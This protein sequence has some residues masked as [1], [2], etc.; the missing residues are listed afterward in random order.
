MIVLGF[1]TDSAEPYEG[2]TL[3]TGFILSQL[4]GKPIEPLT[5]YQSI[6]IE[7]GEHKL[8]GE[9]YW[10]LRGTLDFEDDFTEPGSLTLTTLP[11]TVY[12]IQ[13]DIDEYKHRCR[14]RVIEASP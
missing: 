3:Y 2:G 7:P 4:D 8:G 14:L 12:T 11:D 10:R 9:C 1:T 6:M 13:S 5:Q